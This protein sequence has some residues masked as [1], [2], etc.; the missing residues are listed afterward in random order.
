[1]PSTFPRRKLARIDYC[2][3]ENTSSDPPVFSSDDGPEAS[4]DNY[5]TPR[6]KK[7]YRGTWWDHQPVAEASNNAAAKVDL[8]RNVDSGVWMGSD[9][10]DD[11]AASAARS[12]FGADTTMLEAPDLP[13]EIG[14][15]GCRAIAM[16]S[17]TASKLEAV[18]E[19]L[20]RQTIERCLDDGKEMV[21]LR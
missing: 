7:Q 2:Y 18:T 1:L 12:S 17:P 5:V 9:G 11:S 19:G 6:K 4:I 13:D 3:D 8:I 21:D 15:I 10:T 14:R 16:L 20:A